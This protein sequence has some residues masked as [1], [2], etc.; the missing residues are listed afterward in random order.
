[1][2]LLHALAEAEIWNMTKLAENTTKTIVIKPYVELTRYPTFTET[3]LDIE[4]SEQIKV[5]I[6]FALTVFCTVK[7]RTRYDKMTR[8]M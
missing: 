1:M 8:T 4:V 7:F 3:I 5:E 6:W 2:E